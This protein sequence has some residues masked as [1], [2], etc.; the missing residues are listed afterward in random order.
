MNRKMTA[1]MMKI[2]KKISL[3]SE[4]WI[5]I[6]IKYLSCTPVLLLVS[7]EDEEGEQEE[8]GRAAGIPEGGALVTLDKLK[9]G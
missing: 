5:R 2:L 1:M 3:M 6:L 4:R 8:P 7:I 9:S